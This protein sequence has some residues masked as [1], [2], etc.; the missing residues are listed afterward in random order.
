[1]YLTPC[2]LYQGDFRLA[3][4]TLKRGF[5]AHQ[6]VPDE[7]GGK[8]ALLLTQAMAALFEGNF[9]EAGESID[10]CKDLAG[11]HSLASIEL[12]SLSIAGWLSMSQGDLA[13]ATTLLTECKSKAARAGSAF[14]T[15]SAAHLLAITFLFENKLSRAQRESDEALSIRSGRGSRLF[16]A[17]YLIASGAINMRL[18]KL[19]RAGREL[20]SALRTLKQAKAVQQEANCCLVLALLEQRKGNQAAFRRH[21]RQAFCIGRERGFTYYAVLTPDEQAGLARQAIA[22]NIC[23]D[24]CE[25]LLTGRGPGR[26]L[27]SV[28][29]MGEFTVLRGT[30]PVPEAEWK[31]RRAKSLLKLLVA[32]EGQRLPREQ[33]MDLLWP[34]TG[35]GKDPAMFNA[36]LHRLRRAI[37]PKAAKDVFCIQQEEG[38]VGLNSSS[39]WTDAGQFRLHLR[40]AARLRSQNRKSELLQEY[41]RAIALYRGDFL[42]DDV[43][44]EWSGAMRD[45]LRAAYL[46]ALEDAGELADGSGDRDKAL[47]LFER[48][49]LAEPS[50]EKA[51]RWLMTRYH[52]LDRRSDAVRTYERCERALSRELDLEPEEKTKRLYRSIIGG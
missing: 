7:V 11:V 41:E 29:C 30:R 3:R 14:F 22:E 10:R 17:I 46:Q 2:A 52:S 16:H 13:R 38:M 43:Y 47:Q 33:A 35:G 49:F 48:M 23:V 45:Q 36:L 40:H 19:D 26:P 27:L 25:G 42:A 34:G 4:E 24:Y 39:V 15:G 8:A 5:E 44:E 1:M 32:H 37:E 18:G 31:S 9:S 6:A 21:I 12:L 28:Y 20:R 51:C 50:N